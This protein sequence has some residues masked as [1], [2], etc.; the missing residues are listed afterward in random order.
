MGFMLLLAVSALPIF[1]LGKFVYDMDQ[2]KEPKKLLKELLISGVFSCI[3]VIAISSSLGAFIPLFTKDPVTL[4][5]IE[6]AIYSFL[7]V[8]LVEEGCK[9]L[10][11]YSTTYQHKEFNYTFDMIVY[12]VFVSLGFAL[13]E[14]ILYVLDGGLFTGILRAVTA[15]PAHAS[16]AV[17]MGIFLSHA[18]QYEYVS[19]SK[20]VMFKILGLLVPTA[21]HGIYDTLAF[22]NALLILIMFITTFFT[23]TVIYVKDKQKKDLKISGYNI[24]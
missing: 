22:S 18:K 23:I 2:E 1:L 7:C 14:N 3:L 4:S 24:E 19:K 16:N 8:G 17:F 9:Y 15:V 11:L 20:S 5:F 12:A 13:F 21:L 10:M 6:K